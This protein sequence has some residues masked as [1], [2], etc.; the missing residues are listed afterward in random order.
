LMKNEEVKQ[1]VSG[2]ELETPEG[3]QPRMEFDVASYDSLV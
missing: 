1:S 3:H 2:H